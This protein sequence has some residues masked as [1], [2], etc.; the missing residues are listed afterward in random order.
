MHRI[1]QSHPKLSYDLLFLCK[2]WVCIT[3]Y[4]FFEVDEICVV[5]DYLDCIYKLYIFA[6]NNSIETCSLTFGCKVDQLQPC[7]VT[8][9]HPPLNLDF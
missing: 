2:W 3:N 8:P 9:L 7:L 5:Y 6:P 4:N 1:V